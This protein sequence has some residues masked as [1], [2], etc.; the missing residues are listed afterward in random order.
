MI[1]TL[2]VL[3]S[4][5]VA[6]AFLSACTG[7]SDNIAPNR[8]LRGR[9]SAPQSLMSEFDLGG[10]TAEFP[11]TYS[12]DSA[13]TGDLALYSFDEDAAVQC[14]THNNDIDMWW[15]SPYG[16]VFFHLARPQV[17][18]S[19]RTGSYKGLAKAVYRNSH[20]S[21]GATGSHVYEFTG[22]FNALCRATARTIGGVSFTSQVVVAQ[23]PIDTPYEV[24]GGGG[25]GCDSQIVYDPTQPCPGVGGGGSGGGSSEDPTG[26]LNCYWDYIFVE[27]NYGDG[28][29]WHTWWEGWARICE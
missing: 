26:G 13:A 14:R 11:D 3:S 12:F 21:Q 5:F 27:I 29:G 15:M 9:I 2:R 7:A 8:E 10:I 20:L 22:R 17:F 16:N 4:V 18:V 1:R 28:S 25:E 19:Y 6:G 23:A 24:T